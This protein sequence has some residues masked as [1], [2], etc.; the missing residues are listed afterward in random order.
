MFLFTRTS[1]AKRVNGQLR[2]LYPYVDEV[3]NLAQE[4]NHE[5]AS[6]F[7]VLHGHRICRGM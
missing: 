4:L 5:T 3:E 6:R 2:I 1:C 7:G